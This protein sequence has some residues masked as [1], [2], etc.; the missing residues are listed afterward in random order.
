MTVVHEKHISTTALA[1]E[2]GKESKEVFILLARGG[3]IIKVDGH[4][5]LTAKGRFE[6]GIYHTHPKYGE[7]IAWPESV[8]QHPI[9]SMLPDAP[10]T[11][12]GL[13]QKINLPARLVNLLLAER[14]WLKKHLRGWCLTPEGAA[15]GGQQHENEQTGVPYVTWPESL[16]ENTGYRQITQAMSV[17]GIAPEGKALN[18]QCYKNIAGRLIN[19]WLY[20]AGVTYATDYPL[21]L[22]DE[23]TVDFFVPEI[24]LCIDYWNNHGDASV[25]SAQLEKQQHYRQHQIRFLEIREADLATLDEILARELF[26]H[27][28]AVY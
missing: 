18:G 28:I 12:T 7:Y 23:V 3:W 10:L 21:R 9:F 25:I 11:A 14:G 16:L 13:G 20:L 27:G 24:R 5:Q 1:R 4:W 15:L 2:L 26:R 6:G 19:N 8:R 22:D 17:E